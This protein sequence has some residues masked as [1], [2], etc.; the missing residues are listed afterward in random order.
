M[1]SNPSC[2][3]SYSFESLLLFLF[4]QNKLWLESIIDEKD[5]TF[6]FWLRLLIL[7]LI[8]TWRRFLSIWRLGCLLITMRL[9]LILEGI[10]FISFDK[11]Y[12][13]SFVIVLKAWSW[14]SFFLDQFSYQHFLIFLSL[15]SRSPSLKFS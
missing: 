14:V 12:T 11:T 10:K 5:E 1:F 8:F 4:E 2:V 3:Q 9:F 13:Q 15:E 6:V 7:V